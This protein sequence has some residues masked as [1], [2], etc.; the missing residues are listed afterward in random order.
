MRS[1]IVIAALALTVGV[2]APRYLSKVGP[3]PA[4]AAP[5]VPARVELPLRMR[6]RDRS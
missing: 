1:I 2:L 5:Q 4:P 3:A 6:V